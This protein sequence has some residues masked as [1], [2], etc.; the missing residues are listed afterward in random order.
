MYYITCRFTE[1][2]IT[3]G[4]LLISVSWNGMCLCMQHYQILTYTFYTYKSKKESYRKTN[5]Q[6][7]IRREN[8]RN[9]GITSKKKQ[10]IPP[11]SLLYSLVNATQHSLT[12]L[13]HKNRSELQKTQNKL[14]AEQQQRRSFQKWG[15]SDI[16]TICHPSS[17]HLR[18]QREG[19]Y[20][21]K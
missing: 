8:A 12:H 13:L 18:L 4:E 15:H 7:R 16:D 11:Q 14:P 5:N 2:W 1:E 19:V 10:Q 21:I 6:T 20:F 3:L 9:G 17:R